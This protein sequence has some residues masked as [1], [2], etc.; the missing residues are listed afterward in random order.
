MVGIGTG[1]MRDTFTYSAMFIFT[2]MAFVCVCLQ[3]KVE[4]LWKENRKERHD[5]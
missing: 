3:I 2:E 4:F 1:P 5:F